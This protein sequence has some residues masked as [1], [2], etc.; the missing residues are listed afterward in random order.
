MVIICGWCETNNILVLLTRFVPPLLNTQVALV[1]GR[2]GIARQFLHTL[3][4]YS[5]DLYQFY[6]RKYH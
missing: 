1:N 6:I 4:Y 5:S 2:M 3:G